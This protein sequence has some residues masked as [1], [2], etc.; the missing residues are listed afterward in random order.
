M[1]QR[2]PFPAGERGIG[3]TGG[4]PARAGFGT[5]GSR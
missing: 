1:A 4:Q 5:I 2:T 3:G